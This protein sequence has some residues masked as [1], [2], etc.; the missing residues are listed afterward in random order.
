MKKKSAYTLAEILV[1]I[2]IIGLLSV[3]VASGIN[4]AHLK[5]NESTVLSDFS[6]FAPKI[7]EYF[8]STEDTASNCVSVKNYST[9]SGI[10]NMNILSYNETTYI[11]S[12]Y[13]YTIPKFWVP[14]LRKKMVGTMNLDYDPRM[15]TSYCYPICT[16]KYDPWNNEYKIYTFSAK[17]RTSISGEV[18]NK[19]LLIVYSGGKNGKHDKI[20]D[21]MLVISKL[22][23]VVSYGTVGF[24]KN[25]GNVVV[26][27]AD[28]I[29][30][31]TGNYTN[32]YDNIMATLVTG[33]I[34]T[35][36]KYVSKFYRLGVEN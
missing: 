31:K 21:Y 35:N 6:S 8:E 14:A 34:T 29:F 4:T 16:G 33:D 1:V 25:I 12:N 7:V 15:T 36:E 13:S 11:N 19:D 22:N 28:D 26:Y 24:T 30:N 2:M 27:E 18:D 17:Q 20:G 10:S 9:Y 3:S 5:D 32:G 23:G